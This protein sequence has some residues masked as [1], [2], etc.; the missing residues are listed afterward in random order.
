MNTYLITPAG[1][2]GSDSFFVPARNSEEAIFYAKARIKREGWH[3][4]AGWEIYL[5]NETF[6]DRP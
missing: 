5:H 3:S 1:V 2:L 4:P 6:E